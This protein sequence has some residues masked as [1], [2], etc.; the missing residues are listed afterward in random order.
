MVWAVT[1]EGDLRAEKMAAIYR[2]IA[3][4]PDAALV[5]LADRLA[6]VEA[7]PPGS[8]HRE[9]YRRERGEFGIHVQQ[10]VPTHAW[11]RLDAAYQAWSRR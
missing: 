1:A 3:A 8:K 2:K 5:K 4:E 11:R 7:A 10:R 6:N 9:R